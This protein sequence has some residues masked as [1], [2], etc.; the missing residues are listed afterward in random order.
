M[1]EGA[2][3][4]MQYPEGF[5]L[6]TADPF[7]SFGD[8]RWVLGDIERGKTIRILI[9]NSLKILEHFFDI[10]INRDERIGQIS[11]KDAVTAFQVAAF[12]HVE[13]EVIAG[14]VRLGLRKGFEGAAFV[15]F[16]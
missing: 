1:L 8:T 10:Y 9:Q 16:Q 2:V 5:S 11:L 12:G 3:L 7:P 15:A 6:R 14:K 13:R 4:V